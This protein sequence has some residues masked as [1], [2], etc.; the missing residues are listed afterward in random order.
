MKPIRWKYHWIHFTSYKSLPFSIDLFIKLV[1]IFLIM[2]WRTWNQLWRFDQRYKTFPGIATSN[3]HTKYFIK[4]LK[5][6]KWF[7]N[8]STTSNFFNYQLLN[9]DPC[10]HRLTLHNGHLRK[11]YIESHTVLLTKIEN[12]VARIRI[13]DVLYL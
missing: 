4:Q 6:F 2:I 3:R 5:C 8:N 11:R 12:S 13:Y 1:V 9:F 10:M 7:D